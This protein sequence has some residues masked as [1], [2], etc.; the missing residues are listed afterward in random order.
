MSL[1]LGCASLSAWSNFVIV[2]RNLTLSMTVQLTIFR[3]RKIDVGRSRTLKLVDELVDLLNRYLARVW[4]VEYPEYLLILLLV[5]VELVI[6][7][8]ESI[9]NIWITFSFAVR[10]CSLFVL[11]GYL[12]GF[13]RW[14]NH[15]AREKLLL[16]RFFI[17]FYFQY[18]L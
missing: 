3:L 14:I 17:H 2:T 18:L 7:H 16:I 15:I 4:L 13:R 5:E 11:I 12:V 6:L 1:C 8:V 9:Q 10:I